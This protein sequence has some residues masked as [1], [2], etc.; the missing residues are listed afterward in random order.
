M[1]ASIKD[2]I[3]YD[4]SKKI[5]PEKTNGDAIGVYKFSQSN[6]KI[7]F[8]EIDY[9]IENSVKDKLFTYA[10]QKI[11]KKINIYSISTKGKPWIE[12]DDL[13][14]LNNFKKMVENQEL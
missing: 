13:N 3:I 1:K 14:D 10:V 7:L 2:N 5:L 4:V 9:L 11:L 6:I 8:N 12:I